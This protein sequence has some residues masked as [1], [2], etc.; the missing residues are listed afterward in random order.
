[1][2]GTGSNHTLVLINGISINDQSTTQGLHDFGVD[3]IQTIQQIEVYPGPNTSN[4]GSNAIGGA[5]NI[6]TTGD[7][8]D[9]Y[10]FNLSNVENFDLLANKTFVTE[11]SSSINFKFGAVK[12]KTNSAKFGGK[13]DDEV[14]NLSGNLNYEKWINDNTK[15]TNSTYLRQTIAE[16]DNSSTNEI[17]YE[18]D[19]KMLTSQF[20]ISNF[21][22]DTKNDIFVFYNNY[23]RE[24]DEVG[25]IDYY[26]SEA[27][28]LK[29]DSS[30]IIQDKLSFGLGSEYRYDW[31]EF[32]N[33]GSSYSSS[34]KGNYDN[35]S[36]YGNIGFDLFENTNFA[37]FLRRDKNKI[38]GS[39]NTYK[40]NIEQKI[41]N[42][43]LGITRMT[44]LRNPTLYEFFGS[45]SSGYSGNRSL[46][47]EKSDTNQIYSKYR[48]SDRLIFSL[49]GY[50]STIYDQ[51]EYV[52]KQYVNSLNVDLNQSGIDAE[53]K[54]LGKKSKILFYSNFLSSKKKN[55][56][57]QLRRP[58]K[59]YGVNFNKE[60]YNKIFGNLNL[61]LNY[62]HYGKHFDTHSSTWSTVEMDSTD[63]VDLS[64][65]KYF[66]NVEF[67]LKSSNL[68]DE[69]YQRPHGYSQDGQRFKFG[70]KTIY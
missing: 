1:M 38:S 67:Y 29:V 52:N 48:F 22:K 17:G 45:D 65:R 64:L 5:I 49:T 63:I 24:Y 31:G 41:N 20:G 4:F 37:T 25:V 54:Y 13:E 68:L 60:I 27:I 18:G 26:E 55:G 19:N 12:S 40:L 23:D 9:Y 47:S 21:S 10:T 58:E 42:F 39:H 8:K 34:T 7:Y 57:D 43:S 6:I 50:K 36:I 56:S 66:G 11:D 46:K 59:T 35:F 33:N 61:N 28:G 53:I 2:R 30:K 15:I 3:F 51:L 14:N 16:Y 62:R 32:Q 69:K 44:A 70:I